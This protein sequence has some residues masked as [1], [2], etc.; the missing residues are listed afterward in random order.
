[1]F[2]GVAEMCL[3]CNSGS[4]EVGVCLHVYLERDFLSLERIVYPKQSGLQWSQQWV[5]PKHS[6]QMLVGSRQSEN[7]VGSVG[8]QRNHRY[9]HR[10]SASAYNHPPH[11]VYTY[12][13]HDWVEGPELEDHCRK[14]KMVVTCFE[15]VLVECDNSFDFMRYRHLLHS[16][17]KVHHFLCDT[18]QHR[19]DR[20]LP[21][22]KVLECA[23]KARI[24]EKTCKRPNV[25]NNVWNQVL[26]VEVGSELC[27]S[28]NTQRSCL[29]E[30][31]YLINHCNDGQNLTLYKQVSGLFLSTWC[32][33]PLHPS[34][35][36]HVGIFNDAES[37]GVIPTVYVKVI[38]AF[39]FYIV[40]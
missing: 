23:E 38:V 6:P 22:L 39:V 16:L 5:S 28:L 32:K 26:R 21:F 14:L 7:V 18:P 20:F 30:N 3:G 11:E 17:D 13:Q 1:C 24:E 10:N 31:K 36:Y 27:D 8:R 25:T 9:R 15:E 12:G 37:S 40:R 33:L 29:I 19:M 4:K 35:A 34:L 2:A